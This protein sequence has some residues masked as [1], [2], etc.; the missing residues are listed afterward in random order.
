MSFKGEMLLLNATKNR[1]TFA[2]GDAHPFGVGRR[3]MGIIVPIN[4]DETITEPEPEAASELTVAEENEANRQ[5]C[6]EMLR[7]LDLASANLLQYAV[8]LCKDRFFQ[9][10]VGADTEKEA[11]MYLLGYCRMRSRIEIVDE[12]PRHKFGTLYKEFKETLCVTA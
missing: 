11:R 1:A 8:M 5:E 12:G 6:V 2:L 7:R 9:R 3:Y 10:H 4:D